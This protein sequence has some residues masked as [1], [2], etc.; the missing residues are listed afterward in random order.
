MNTR[1]LEQVYNEIPFQIKESIGFPDAH[2]FLTN[3]Q[4]QFIITCSKMKDR[5]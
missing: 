3:E 5:Q 4:E 1:R 2:I